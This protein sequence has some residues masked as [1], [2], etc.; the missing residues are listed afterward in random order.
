VQDFVNGISKLSNSG[1]VIIVEA[2]SIMQI[3]D[4][5]Q[6]DTIYHEHFSYISATGIQKLFA[7]FGLEIVG[8]ESVST[9][10]GS[11]RFLAR[12][13]GGS[14]EASLEQRQ[15]LDLRLSYE[16]N[17]GLFDEESWARV[18]WLVEACVSKFKQWLEDRSESTVTVAYGAAAKGV[19]LLAAAG[20]TIGDI[21]VV[22]DNSEEKQ[23]KLF[24]VVMAQIA[25]ESDFVLNKSSRRHRYV[26]FPWN[27][28][29][30]IAPR[31]R[32]F[33]P[34]AEIIRAVPELT[35]LI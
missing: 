4:Q 32:A 30:E 3:L 21:D 24:P 28:S 35:T 8:A 18:S 27:L 20:A 11:A 1:T 13:F 25:T 29:H 22:I 5:L 16:R 31:I 9:H 12:R 17:S 10:G 19:T 34:T 6:F 33:D 2:P 15:E 7:K 23:G 26:V 14:F